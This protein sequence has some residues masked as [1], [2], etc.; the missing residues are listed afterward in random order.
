MIR[1]S[2][3]KHMKTLF[4]TPE[5]IHAFNIGLAE[6][7]NYIPP[8]FQPTLET[9]EMIEWE[10]HYYSVGRAIGFLINLFVLAG[11]IKFCLR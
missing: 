11:L 6:G 1:Y 4:D 8:R 10:Y 5:E 3:V 9:I 2:P 7:F